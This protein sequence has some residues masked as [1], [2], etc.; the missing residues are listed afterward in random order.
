MHRD[1]PPGAATEERDCATIQTTRPQM[2]PMV[3]AELWPSIRS[4][5]PPEAWDG[6]EPEGALVIHWTPRPTQFVCGEC[7]KSLG[8]YRAY[9]ARGE[10]G[11]V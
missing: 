4:D 6:I 9:Q 3:I 7:G 11:V 10:Y 8:H 1:P 2:A 5:R